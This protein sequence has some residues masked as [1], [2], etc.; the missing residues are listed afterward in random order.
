MEC[1]HYMKRF[2]GERAAIRW[3]CF[4]GPERLLRRYV[5]NARRQAAAQHH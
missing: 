5:Q 4:G 1:S 3:V 2:D